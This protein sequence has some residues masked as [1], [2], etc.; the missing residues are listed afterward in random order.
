MQTMDFSWNSR[1][2]RDK[3][4]PTA[5]QPNVRTFSQDYLEHH[6]VLFTYQILESQVVATI[7][8]LLVQRLV[9]FMS[10]PKFHIDAAF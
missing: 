4:P 5:A 10:S 9:I 3:A 7:P 8:I 1:V 2:G 6:L